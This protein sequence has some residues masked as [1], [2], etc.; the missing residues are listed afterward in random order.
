MEEPREE[1]EC[2][3]MI[4]VLGAGANLVTFPTVLDWDESKTRV[5]KRKGNVGETDGVIA[6]YQ[7]SVTK[8]RMIELVARLTRVQKTSLKLLQAE[9]LWQPLTDDAVLVDYVWIETV[10]PRFR[11]VEDHSRPWL[12]SIGLIASTN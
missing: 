10:R 7:T 5:I 12:T 9:H 1:G 6:D 4:V 11:A 8:P 3:V 2:S